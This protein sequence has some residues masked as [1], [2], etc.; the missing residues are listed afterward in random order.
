MSKGKSKGP[1]T[2]GRVPAAHRRMQ[3]GLGFIP[4][5][6]P[7]FRSLDPGDG[8]E[9]IAYEETDPGLAR[10]RKSLEREIRFA[11][12]S[13]RILM[14]NKK[15]EWK[16]AQLEEK[17]A[18]ISRLK[19]DIDAKRV[20]YTYAEITVDP[21]A[22][23]KDDLT[24]VCIRNLWETVDHG[25]VLRHRPLLR[26]ADF[27][28]LF[29]CGKYK[30]NKTFHR[31]QFGAKGQITRHHDNVP[32]DATG[33]IWWYTSPFTVED[34]HM[35]GWFRLHERIRRLTAKEAR[36][37]RRNIEKSRYSSLTGDA[38]WIEWLRTHPRPDR[39]N[40]SEIFSVW[41]NIQKLEKELSQAIRFHRCSHTKVSC[42]TPLP[43]FDTLVKVPVSLG[44]DYAGGEIPA[45]NP[46]RQ[47]GNVALDRRYAQYIVFPAFGHGDWENRYCN[48]FVAKNGV[49]KL[50]ESTLGRLIEDPGNWIDLTWLIG[51]NGASWYT[52]TESK[53]V[54]LQTFDND[55]PPPEIIPDWD[56]NR[57]L[58]ECLRQANKIEGLVFGRESADRLARSIVE[59]KDLPQTVGQTREFVVWLASGLPLAVD[60]MPQLTGRA[61]ALVLGAQTVRAAA[62]AWLF[63]KF[64]VEPTAHDVNNLCSQTGNYL[65]PMRAGL[66]SM[67]RSLDQIGWDMTFKMKHKHREEGITGVE[68]R[69]VRRTYWIHLPCLGL[70]GPDS[71][72]PYPTGF[73]FDA[74]LI[75]LPEKTKVCTDSYATET[76]RCANGTVILS[77]LVTNSISHSDYSE[78]ITWLDKQ[79]RET[80]FPVCT[81]TTW[82]TLETNVFARFA[83]EDIA[84][85]YGWKESWMSDLFGLHRALT[86]SWE[87]LPLSFIADWFLS[88]REVMDALNLQAFLKTEGLHLQPLDGVWLGHKFQFWNGVQA[89]NAHVAE[90]HLGTFDGLTEH[91]IPGIPESWRGAK[92]SVWIKTACLAGGRGY[93]FSSSEMTA[94]ERWFSADEHPYYTDSHNY[95]WDWA[96]QGANYELPVHMPILSIKVELNTRDSIP[97]AVGKGTTYQRYKIDEALRP[98]AFVPVADMKVNAGKLVSLAAILAN[99]V[100]IPGSPRIV[101]TRL[102]PV[103]RYTTFSGN[104]LNPYR[105]FSFR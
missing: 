105:R 87:I 4:Q 72:Q 79:I 82:K 22:V 84:A 90:V 70:N 11:R 19:A 103:A 43:E 102:S 39:F 104:S 28:M 100:K 37:L 78:N 10:M 38:K 63:W 23:G 32:R 71:L 85:A 58:T 2:L 5:F 53:A 57:I 68:P 1:A 99:L 9:L 88:T 17:R 41:N 89:P 7:T 42:Q 65:Q 15:K 69:E 62:A 64:G 18:L 46:A 34:R 95:A 50:Q 66:T 24:E 52:S 12:S 16:R 59:C 83:A 86:T 80:M 51:R 33:A 49:S 101:K 60:N 91:G 27:Q 29:H 26:P 97:R 31:T 54:T 14:N 98:L 55:W 13:L 96:C 20:K 8:N 6:N 36:K 30:V 76:D 25:G 75:A 56:R 44:N 74:G 92:S 45:Y 40:D 47:A 3:S 21:E 61:K 67:Y 77:D 73:R 81:T 93:E 35:V 94:L 48:R